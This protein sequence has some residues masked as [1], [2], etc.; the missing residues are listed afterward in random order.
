MWERIGEPLQMRNYY[1]WLSPQADGYMGGGMRFR[2]RDFMKLGQLYVD[3]GSWHGSRIVST[4]WVNRS[5]LPR[6]DMGPRSKYGYLWWMIE[7]PHNGRTLQAYFASGNGGNEVMVIP[8]LDLVIAVY[9]GNYNE[10]AGWEMVLR[11]I[12]QYVLPAVEP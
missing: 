3:H 4:E 2:P 9:G 12:P 7:Y 6:Y 1:M 11:L 10:A 8:G 5:T